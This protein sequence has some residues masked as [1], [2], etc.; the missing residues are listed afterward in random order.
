[1]PGL[2]LI[3]KF[4]PAVRA[5][6]PKPAKQND[7]DKQ[8]GGNKNKPPFIQFY[9]TEKRAFV[10][11]TIFK[12]CPDCQPTVAKQLYLLSFFFGPGLVA[13]RRFRDFISGL[14]RLCRYF[15]TKLKT[16]AFQFYVCQNFAAKHL[17]ASRFIGNMRAIQKIGQPRQKM[18][19]QIIKYTR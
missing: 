8:I 15:R 7:S 2:R 13:D 17:V 6:A 9:K 19:A 3:V 4:S 16:V 14:Q 12:Q 10:I 5:G 11:K 18:P 1:M